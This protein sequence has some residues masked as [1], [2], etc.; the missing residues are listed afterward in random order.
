MPFIVGGFAALVALAA[1]ILANVD[2]LTSLWRAALAFA[3]GWVGGNVWYVLTATA[4]PPA[5]YSDAVA[6]NGETV[7]ASES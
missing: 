7:P 4:R 3:L 5:D 6:S 1:G 2:P